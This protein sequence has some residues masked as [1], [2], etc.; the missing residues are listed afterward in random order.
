MVALFLGQPEPAPGVQPFWT[1][2]LTTGVAGNSAGYSS[3]SSLGGISDTTYEANGA[4]HTIAALSTQVSGFLVVNLAIRPAPASYIAANF[5]LYIRFTRGA[6]ILLVGPVE[7]FVGGADVTYRLSD[8]QVTLVRGIFF[9]ARS[10]VT[11]EF[12][13]QDPS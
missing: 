6:N 10:N 9:P 8:E 13:D 11:V 2:N 4:T 5:P 12:F 7:E 1:A 3:F